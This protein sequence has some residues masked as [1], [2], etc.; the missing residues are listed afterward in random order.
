[1]SKNK[2][3]N[4][5]NNVETAAEE[6]SSV[7]ITNNKIGY[8]GIVKIA[9]EQNNRIIYKK[10]YHNSGGSE[11]YKF[12]CYCLSDVND[13]KQ[14]APKKIKLF[15]N[16]ADTPTQPAVALEALTKGIIANSCKAD[17]DSLPGE[18]KYSQKQWFATLHFIIPNAYIIG[19]NTSEEP[20]TINEIRL[21][22]I[23]SDIDESDDAS[24]LAERAF[25]ADFKFTTDDGQKWDPITVQTVRNS[26]NLI[27]D[28]TMTFE[29]YNDE[30]RR[31]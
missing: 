31:V 15:C 9:I 16:Q 8:R 25:S 30:T 13:A 7:A 21:Y 5:K 20:T 28:W 2:K 1:M 12:L 6:I 10:E 18:N 27:I 4:P 22:P 26:Y 11:L 17:F 14:W 24:I 23:N 19:S 29:N 3:T